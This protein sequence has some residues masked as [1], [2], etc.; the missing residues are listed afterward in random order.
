MRHPET[1]F[2]SGRVV[3]H[4]AQC[5]VTAL[6]IAEIGCSGVIG[7]PKNDES[8]TIPENRPRDPQSQTSALCSDAPPNSAMPARLRRLSARQYRNLMRDV[9][10]DHT[11]ELD[12][13]PD[14]GPALSSLSVERYESVTRE[15]VHSHIRRL[16]RFAPCDITQTGDQRCAES[17]IDA[18]AHRLF[19]RPLRADERTR[20]VDTFRAVR[21]EHTFSESI[22]VIVRILLL[23]PHL[24]YLHE[25]G[26]TRPELPANVRRRTPTELA[27]NVSLLLLDQPPDAALLSAV[28]DGAFDHATGPGTVAAQITADPRAHQVMKE[29]ILNDWLKLHGDAAHQGILELP[30]PGYPGDSAALRRGMHADAEKLVERM[31]SEGGTLTALFTDRRAWVNKELAAFYGVAPPPDGQEFIEREVPPHYTGYLLRPMFTAIFSNPTQKSPLHRGGQLLKMLCRYPGEP[32]PTADDTPP[33]TN[34][35]NGPQTVRQASDEKTMSDPVCASCHSVV[36][37]L[38]FALENYD[39][40]GKFHTEER[41]VDGDGTEHRLPVD[42]RGELPGPANQPVTVA[43]GVELAA[44]LATSRELRSCFADLWII[45]ALGRSP[46]RDETCEVD[47]IKERFAASGKLADLFQAL[48]NSWPYQTLASESD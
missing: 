40:L 36:N 45:R 29:W 2:L 31:L 43:D 20:L 28:R 17:L 10:D 19:R 22:D 6:A 44:A 42:S 25:T 39:R 18:L 27:T 34:G 4:L 3:T 21:S 12:L 7:T 11:L 15:L 16:N 9:F 33:P 13:A 8:T 48:A 23:S 35:E 24:L 30:R 46:T 41:I 32:P 47:R 14:D 26:E 38:G 37:P 1:G 5:L